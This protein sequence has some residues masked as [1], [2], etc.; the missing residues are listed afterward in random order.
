V[1]L[2]TG[3]AL[4][5]VALITGAVFAGLS[6][7][8]SGD[9]SDKRGS[10]VKTSGPAACT[11]VGAPGVPCADLTNAANDRRTFANV[12]FWS[13]VGAGTVGAGTLIY[14]L[15]APK[16]T[17]KTDGLTLA[18]TAGPQGASLEVSGTW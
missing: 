15:L 10:L 7:A 3:G 18:P 4:A 14:A 6:N 2:A 5:G 13:F 9:A 16:S 8:K 17:P 1:V 12:A 11:G